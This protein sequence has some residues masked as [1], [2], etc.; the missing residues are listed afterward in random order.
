MY[1]RIVVP[2]DGSKLAEEALPDAERL[3]R[4]MDAPMHLLRVVDLTQL[5]W[6]GQF[7]GAMEYVASEQALAADDEAAAS[8]LQTVA[9][10]MTASGLSVVTEVR[11]GP[12]SRVLIAAT[13]PGDLIVM[14]SHGRSGMTRWFLGS[15]AE[16]I[17]RHA[18]VPILLV[19]A[20]EQE[21]A[22]VEAALA[23][24]NAT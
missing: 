6:Y 11:R 21:I 19:K 14:A 2:L 10:R 8:Y 4:L 17:L 12:T 16:E 24:A 20:P 13:R 22:R 23:T 18:S 15:V 9:E 7:G 5:P 3:A 1:Q